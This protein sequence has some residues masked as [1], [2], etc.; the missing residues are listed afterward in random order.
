MTSSARNNR[1]VGMFRP[2]ARLVCRLMVSFGL[3]GYSTG[4]SPLFTRAH[5]PAPPRTSL[6]SPLGALFSR[7]RTP[8]AG[9]SSVDRQAGCAPRRAGKAQACLGQGD[10]TGANVWACLLQDAD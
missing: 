5:P 2:M 3:T 10:K 8:A 1:A 9:E 7:T 4:I 6:V